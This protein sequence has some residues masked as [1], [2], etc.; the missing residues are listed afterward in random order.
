MAYLPVMLNCVALLLFLVKVELPPPF[1]RPVELSL[2]DPP[3]ASL[4]APDEE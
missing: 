1:G 2:L 3:G 4:D